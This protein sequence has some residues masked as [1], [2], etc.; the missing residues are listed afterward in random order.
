MVPLLLNAAAVQR[1]DPV[2]G[3]TTTAFT[4]SHT[5]S[6]ATTEASV[7]YAMNT[8]TTTPSLD[9]AAPSST[10]ASSRIPTTGSSTSN[11]LAAQYP[12]NSGPTVAPQPTPTRSYFQGPLSEITTSSIPFSAASGVFN[13]PISAF[14]NSGYIPSTVAAASMSGYSSAE[15]SISDVLSSVITSS[16]VDSTTE[17]SATY[18]PFAITVSVWS[19]LSAELLTD[20]SAIGEITAYTQGSY[21]SMTVSAAADTTAS[22]TVAVDE[23]TSSSSFWSNSSAV[24]GTFAGVGVAMSGLLLGMVFLLKRRSR[25]PVDD[26]KWEFP[27]E[28]LVK[29]TYAKPPY[30]PGAESD[31]AFSKR[32]SPPPRMPSDQFSISDMPPSDMAAHKPMTAT[33]S[34]FI[35]FSN[36]PNPYYTRQMIPPPAAVSR[37]ASSYAP[38]AQRTISLGPV[39]GQASRQGSTRNGV[40]VMQDTVVIAPG[41]TSGA[42]S[43]NSMTPRDEVGLENSYNDR[44]HLESIINAYTLPESMLD[45]QA[46]MPAI[47]NSYTVQAGLAPPAPSA[48][49][50]Y[51]SS[52]NS[53]F[54]SSFYE[55]S[56]SLASSARGQAL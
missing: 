34:S 55:P 20:S 48:R 29:T 37:Q 47:R 9:S 46:P 7:Y 41:R 40:D 33:S 14:T 19:L 24:G 23:T 49:G 18:S 11:V 12:P 31:S 32:Y 5:S 10:S 25:P 43:M 36:L 8:P 44:S 17:A 1:A 52:A 22:S 3:S 45:P 27:R 51:R 2:D 21:A 54:V 56:L 39:P 35:H 28:S 42:P 50:S 38:H 13:S 26:E 53:S 6:S 4:A 30:T 16:T 15:A